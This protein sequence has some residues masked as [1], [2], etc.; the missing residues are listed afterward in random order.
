MS[1]SIDKRVVEMQ[2]DN[3][4][5]EDNVQESLR[6]L[7]N[8]K[9][10]L[11]LNDATRSL[12]ELDE[13]AK[14]FS[15]MHIADGIDSIA[16]RF[17]TLGIIGVTT[18][19]RITVQ[20]LETAAAISKALILEPIKE[21][22][23]EY[24]LMLNSLQTTMTGTGLSAE[25]VQKQLDRL[26]EYADKT[27]YSTRDMLD[28]LPKFTNAGVELEPA[29]TAMIGIANAAAHAGKGAR[30]ASIAYYN[31]GQSIAT[32]YLSRIDYNS[33]NNAGIATLQWKEAMVEAAIA[34]GTLTKV[35]ENA[36]QAGNKV[37]A[38]QELFIEGLQERWATTDVMMKVFGDYGSE[39]TEIGKKAM[40]AAQDIRDYHM[41]MDSLKA[42]VGTGW[43][44]TWQLI[45]G[46]LDEAKELWTGIYK[47]VSGVLDKTSDARNEI[48]KGWKDEG[49]RTALIN[50]FKNIF[51][52]LASI[53]KPIAEAFREV[54]PPATGKRLAELTKAFE[55]LTGKFKIG[56]KAAE[57][58]KVV[59]K[60]LFSAIHAV[61]SVIGKVINF[62]VD[63]IGILGKGLG[64]IANGFMSVITEI[65]KFV[66]IIAEMIAASNILNSA[67]ENIKVVFKA[68]FSAIHAV[69]S[70]IGKVI[71]FIVENLN[72]ALDVLTGRF[73]GLG[74]EM[75]VGFVN[76]LDNLIAKFQDLRAEFPE[77][78]KFATGV[79]EAFK[80]IGDAVSQGVANFDFDKFLA[81]F[82][83]G[84]LAV[85]VL[86]IRKFIIALTGVVTKGGDFL[87]SITGILDGVRGCLEAWQQQLKAGALMKIAVAI[88]V[89][90]GALFIL[91]RIDSGALAKALT[92]ISIL[93]AELFAGINIFATAMTEPGFR[94]M[95]TIPAILTGL[96][97]AV[98][99]L[100]FAMKKISTLDWDEILKGAVGVGVLCTILAK[101]ATTL[102]G[103][104]GKLVGA[105]FSFILMGIAISI[106]ARSV[107]KLGN[108]DFGDLL[109][110]LMGVG[111]LLFGLSMFMSK[112]QFSKSGFL[113]GV[114]LMFLATA[115]VILVNAIAKI[116]EI[117][118]GELIKGLAGFGAVLFAISMFSKKLQ[119]PERMVSI[120][121]SLMFI[122]TSMLI[123]AKAISVMGNIPT[124]IMAKGLFVLAASL[125]VIVVALNN[126]EKALPGAAAL[127]VIAAALT[128]LAIPLKIFGSMSWSAIGK[129]LATLAG[130]LLLFGVTAALL[131]PLA[132]AL[133]MLGDAVLLFGLGCMAAG[134]GVKFF[135]AAVL[136]LIG[137][138]AGGI[139]V[140]VGLVVG[141]LELIPMIFRKLGEGVL[142]FAE[143]IGTGGPA[144]TSAF[145]ALMDGLLEAIVVVI[146]KAV[147]AIL[148]LLTA[149]LEALIQYTPKIVK[150]GVDFIVAFLKGIADNIGR[151]IEAAVMIVVSFINGISDMIPRI[152]DAAFDL[153]VNFIN[154]LAYAIA[155]NVPLVVDAIWN[156][157]DA[158]IYAA[159]YAL[160]IASPSTVFFDIG[161]DV[162][163]G[164]ID[165]IKSKIKSIAEWAA[166]MGKTAINAAKEAI[167]SDSPSKEFIKL[168]MYSS[169]GFAIG[170]RNFA[171]LA[172]TE[173][174]DVG[175]NAIAALKKSISKISNVIN[176]NI[177][178]SVTIRP[179]LDLSN[180]T[181]GAKTIDS[182][183]SQSRGL[184]VENINSK[185]LSINRNVQ[186]LPA[187]TNELR[188]SKL[189][190]LLADL[191]DVM[192]NG[193]Q[194][195]THDGEITVKGVND[196]NE[197]VG[198]T[199]VLAREIN[200][201]NRRIPKRVSILPSQA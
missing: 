121:F 46:D 15:L 129:G 31:L 20:A 41:L 10:A 21:G 93:F 179:V 1:K 40:A 114:Q 141:L 152:I 127:L 104:S 164:F 199:K 52:G 56:S 91:S 92:A 154:G 23:S 168:G 166:K 85:I 22:F 108:L 147:E 190:K 36:Y 18:L 99:I 33:V 191:K 153:V 128:I 83:T 171:H 107:E 177:D 48:L 19:Q 187:N 55:V 150:V 193:D 59:F 11:E 133:L 88:A 95:F 72:K 170:L 44:D 162:I 111:A 74:T 37:F 178:T 132:P 29:T 188:L 81:G 7:K 38:L 126:L 200:W 101:S 146:P 155:E 8:L 86:A 100:G 182:L 117:N 96:A 54:F 49:G 122:A 161:K 189:E 176:G 184:A 118:P 124:D 34:Q 119:A 157:I 6:S 69:L 172:E 2:F 148:K 63:I 13:V 68:L 51:Q 130:V 160:G 67:A 98:L 5:F 76:P 109:K 28:N 102:A 110:G 143:V 39:F 158:I 167:D 80:I 53:Y 77:L 136:A 4:H 165:G 64:P 84:L 125:V 181:S 35:N 50:S 71:N 58:I 24:E 65:A 163:Y 17:T 25:E 174:K 198:Y 90:A 196:M 115:M 151:V 26:D 113:L 195:V 149:L 137:I 173:A 32:G 94:A 43:K 16:N 135:V 103:I 116:S 70:V 97:V 123:F 186:T 169:E 194:R 9:K 45:V 14:N 87:G 139:A 62:T 73:Q 27:V 75:S 112:T 180:V 134:A 144:L 79:S 142:A 61:L 89:L 3:K 42:G 156:L 78:D 201:D 60:A 140:V 138:G 105:S 131:A 47:V 185:A 120:G 30:E 197:L 192:G 145:I 183:I 106:L 57:N 175:K 66:T 159:K 82:N 12:S